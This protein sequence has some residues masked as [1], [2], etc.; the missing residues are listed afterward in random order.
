[1][2]KWTVHIWDEGKYVD[3]WTLNHTLA[4]SLPA[5]VI[6]FLDMPYS[7]GF[8][9]TVIVALAWEVIELTLGIREQAWNKFFDVI[10]A[11]LGFIGTYELMAKN[12]LNNKILFIILLAIYVILE[13]WGYLT[14]KWRHQKE[15]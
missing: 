4:G 2:K 15:S 6:F 8:L 9:F 14:V 7:Y 13:L 1:M 10:T 12:V 11:I 3:L 5:G